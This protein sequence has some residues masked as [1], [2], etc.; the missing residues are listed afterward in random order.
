VWA[1]SPGSHAFAAPAE[2]PC[3][4]APL[5]AAPQGHRGPWLA[6]LLSLTNLGLVAPRRTVWEG[7]NPK[8]GGK[9]RPGSLYKAL[10]GCMV[11]LVGECLDSSK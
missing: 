6:T 1:L 4:P 8:P 7:E 3:C 2:D 11:S 5:A 10:P 9:R